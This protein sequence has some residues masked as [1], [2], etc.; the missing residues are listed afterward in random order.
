MG[1]G[2][3]HFALQVVCPE[4]RSVPQDT[5][6]DDVAHEKAS[7]AAHFVTALKLSG[8]PTFSTHAVIVLP[9]VAKKA[10]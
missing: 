8:L 3:D 9:T 10:S 7:C 4:R 5:N 2:G 1:C 6:G